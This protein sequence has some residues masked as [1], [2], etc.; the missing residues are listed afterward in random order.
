MPFT[1]YFNLPQQFIFFVTSRCNAR[2]DFCL[3]LEQVN[4]PVSI[5]EELR[6]DEIIQFTRN[7][8]KLF[9]LGISGGEPFV[10]A[11]L[12]QICQA[13]IDNCGVSVIDIPS[14]F[15]FT[16]NT[17]STVEK[18]VSGNP[19]VVLDLQFSLDNIGI[20]HDQS[21]KV[22]GLYDKAIVTFLALEKL[23]NSYKNLKL[24]INIV[25]LDDNKNE[26]HFIADE[27]T[28]ILKPNRIQITYP[29][30]LLLGPSASSKEVD[31]IAQYIKK[32]Q[33]IDARYTSDNTNDLYSLG[34]RSL[35]NSYHNLLK[36]AVERRR[37]TSSYCN[38]GKN[39]IVLNEKGDVFPCEPLWD[40]KLGNIRE[41]DY[42]IRK[43]IYSK[44]YKKF[45][46][47]YLSEKKCNC[48]YS[49]AINSGITTNYSHYPKLAADAI[50]LA[51]GKKQ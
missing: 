36:K 41:T 27:I 19:N 14:N 38:A 7:Y 28:K 12:A 5:R 21:R 4:N 16:E 43:I 13:F 26:I 51:Y 46:H 42:D 45:E 17:I 49:C 11:D 24:K 22:K 33:E 35:K 44:E 37:N 40:N 32:A 31:N 15:Y 48:T 34:L 50:K 18:I 30:N 47:K 20:K 29:H 23:R 39:I 8:G 3:Y 25:Y 6:V 1:Q 9:Y 10:R 2:C